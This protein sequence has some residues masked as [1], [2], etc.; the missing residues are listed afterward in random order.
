MA[1]SSKRVAGKAGAPQG[2]SQ[3]PRTCSTQTSVSHAPISK[4]SSAP[5]ENAEETL[6]A[7]QSGEVD[8]LMVS[9]RR[10]KQV[11]SLKGG[12][13]NLSHAGGGHERRRGDSVTGWRCALLQS[14]VCRNDVQATRKTYRSCG[15]V[16]GCGN[17]ARQ[18][19]TL[20]AD[21]RK[22]L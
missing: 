6:R 14:Q 15:A 22:A 9:G 16:A 21:A 8:A 13:P 4:Q 2:N 11:V 1:E 18:I 12:E 17:R 20:L 10:G 19:Q 7:I 3:E 5:A